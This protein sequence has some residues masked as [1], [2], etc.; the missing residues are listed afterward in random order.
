MTILIIVIVLLGIILVGDMVLHHHRRKLNV[1]GEHEPRWVS[2]P[3]GGFEE[4]VC[5]I[6][7]VEMT[8]HPGAQ[9]REEEGL[10]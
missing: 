9:P 7:G 1:D 8:E 4:V 5:D 2:G 10:P 3:G 6:C